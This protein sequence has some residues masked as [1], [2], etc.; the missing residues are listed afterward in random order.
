LAPCL[1]QRDGA[2]APERALTKALAQRTGYSDTHPC[3]ADRLNAIGVEPHLPGFLESSA[4]DLFLGAAVE[5]L[6][7][8]LDER[9]RANVRQW[10]TKRHKYAK[11]SRSQLATLESKA[12][13]EAL[14]DDE[15]WD[16]ARFTE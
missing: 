6:R 3:L 13:A 15:H 16:R 10:W 2:G 11:E 7:Q 12:E 4:A 5:S 8:D 9:W 14:N 1:K